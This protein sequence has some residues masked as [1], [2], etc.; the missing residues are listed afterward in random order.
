MTEGRCPQIT[1]NTRS[2]S[3][4]LIFDFLY[5]FKTVLKC[6]VFMPVNEN[7]ASYHYHKLKAEASNKNILFYAV[8][9]GSSHCLVL[10]IIGLLGRF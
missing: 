7:V 2:I 10:V 8:L 5:I 6:S 9:K 4:A 1:I 3:I